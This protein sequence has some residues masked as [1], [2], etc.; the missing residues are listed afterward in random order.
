[1]LGARW[2]RIFVASALIVGVL[3]IAYAILFSYA[4]SGTPPLRLL[5]SVASGALGRDA[6]AG[7]GTTAAIGLGFHFLIAFIVTGVFFLAAA[8]L[9]ALTTRPVI[10]GALYGIGVY[11]VMNF[12]VM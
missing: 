9:P 7:G 8:R 11:V 1:M 4:R 2:G 12:A 10:I 6:F 5:Q 3:D